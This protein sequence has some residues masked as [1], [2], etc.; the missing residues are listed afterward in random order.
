MKAVLWTHYGSPDVLR[1]GEVEK[2][3]PGPKDVLIRIHAAS[4]TMG[5]CEMRSLTLPLLLRLPMRFYAGMFRPRRIK[6]L[7]QEFS[8]VVES[9]GEKVS[10]FK[11]GDKVLAAGGFGKGAYTEY[12]CMPEEPEEMDGTFAVMPEGM[13]F[14]DAAGV[15]VGGLDAL[16][17]LRQAGIKQGE[18]ILINGAGGS[19]GT[20]AVQLALYYGASVTAVDRSGKLEMLKSLGAETVYDYQQDDFLKT[21][22][23]YDII[24]DLPGVLPVSAALEA[25][26]PRGRFV[27]A[28]PKMR[29]MIRGTRTHTDEKRVIAGAA[30]HYRDDL[31]FLCELITEGRF[32]PVI[33]RTFSLDET[34]DAHRY[35]ES[36]EKRGNVIILVVPDKR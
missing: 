10:L 11:P 14:E 15:P 32:R 30:R 21:D 36:G 34:A 4:V 3:V 33:D 29:Q 7:G 26:N 23:M 35:V 6:V 12:I 5:D 2:P 27:I 20:A 8:G 25:L 31:E 17:F 18:R 24:F 28:N 9:V 22:D 1:M 13:S 16:Y 19:I